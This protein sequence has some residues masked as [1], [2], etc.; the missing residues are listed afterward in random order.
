MYHHNVKE[1]AAEDEKG[2]VRDNAKIAFVRWRERARVCIN[3]VAKALYLKKK[4]PSSHHHRA[5][6]IEFMCASAPLFIILCFNFFTRE[7]CNV[8]IASRRRSA[9]EER[10]MNNRGHIYS[11]CGPCFQRP[12]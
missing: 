8:L 4:S 10:D 5:L 6:D 7:E 3:V 2:G 9:P 1:P 11:L 12:F